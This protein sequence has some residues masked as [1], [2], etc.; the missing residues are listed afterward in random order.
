MNRATAAA[1]ITKKLFQRE[2]VS[3]SNKYFI[4]VAETNVKAGYQRIVSAI[5][6]KLLEET[7]DKVE[8]ALKNNTLLS[9]GHASIAHDIIVASMPHTS[10][11]PNRHSTVFV[12]D[13][14]G[15]HIAV[16]HVTDDPDKQQLAKEE[17]L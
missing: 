5:E 10:D 3:G 2:V 8:R 13:R 16:G 1:T 15:K 7:I 6:P 11:D 17:P 4:Y 9:P 12:H 14:T